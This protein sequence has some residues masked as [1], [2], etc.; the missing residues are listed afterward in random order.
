MKNEQLREENKILEENN[1]D[2][3][4]QNDY[5]KSEKIKLDIQNQSAKE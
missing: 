3:F 1:Q 5:L 2:L 4:N